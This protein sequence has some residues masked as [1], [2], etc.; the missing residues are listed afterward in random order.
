MCKLCETNPVYEFTNKRKL[1]KNCFIRWFDKK[2]L[3]TNRKF[4][5]IKKGDSLVIRGEGYKKAVLEHILKKF[6]DKFL[7]EIK[8]KGNKI[9]FTDTIDTNSKEIIRILINKNANQLNN[10]SPINKNN[11][12]PF[13]LFL[14]EEV[15]L[16]AKLNKLKPDKLKDSKDKIK[17]F[18]D[19]IE[20][21]HPEV[22]RAVVNSFLKLNS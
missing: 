3:F 17:L 22:K 12:K 16:Y 14:D 5:L 18:L 2:F 11:I 15:L 8:R 13:Y 7:I 1:C 20:K 19:E 10:L 4:K 6:K 9:A 21:K